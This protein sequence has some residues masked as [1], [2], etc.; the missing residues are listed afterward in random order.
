MEAVAIDPRT[1][2]VLAIA[3]GIAAKSHGAFDPC[4]A[5]LLVERGLLPRPPRAVDLSSSWRDVELV[6]ER[7]M[8]ARRALWLDLGGIAKGYAVDRAVDALRVA[9]VEQGCVNAGG[10]LRVFG[11]RAE[12]VDVRVHD[13]SIVELLEL[14]DGALA[15]SGGAD[16][17]VSIV[18][19]RCVIADALTKVVLAAPDACAA[20]L[21]SHDAAAWIHDRR[22]GWREAA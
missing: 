6:D 11:P 19:P 4:I 12:R 18:A 7:A 17:T 10:D 8:R 14:A 2:E 5:P 21:R 16:R 3:I 15:S 22:T 1:M 20:L 9:G 13:G